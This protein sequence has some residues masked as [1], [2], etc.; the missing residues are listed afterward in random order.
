M[1]NH[2]EVPTIF[3]GQVPEEFYQEALR[4]YELPRK[5]R[6]ARFLNRILFKRQ[7]EESVLTDTLIRSLYAQA[8]ALE[9]EEEARSNARKDAFDDVTGLPNRRYFLEEGDRLLANV[10]GQRRS[11]AIGGFLD[12]VDFGEDINNTHGHDQGDIALR[13]VGE[14]TCKSLRT[15]RGDIVCR[16][17]GDE[18][19]FI[20]HVTDPTINPRE[21][22]RTLAERLGEVP[23]KNI[24]QPKQ[25]RYGFALLKPGMDA[26][27][28]ITAADIKGPNARRAI[29]SRIN[30]AY[31]SA[32]PPLLK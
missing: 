5:N 28:L 19:A 31:F 14:F 9:G 29:Y 12:I 20:V 11:T 18:F 2:T 15:D 3:L 25:L 4:R 27:A 24:H 6:V 21:M 17:G 23:F 10:G 22:I 32:E 26:R 1:A 16:W 30:P 8:L 7:N 13:E